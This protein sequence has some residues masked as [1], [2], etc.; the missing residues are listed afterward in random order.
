MT[1][2]IVEQNA[3]VALK[4]AAYGYV[5]QVGRIAVE[6]KS[7]ELRQNKEVIESYMGS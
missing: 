7:D 6:G 2:L 4:N 1:L 5:L 3:N